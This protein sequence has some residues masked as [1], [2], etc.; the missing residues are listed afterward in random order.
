MKIALLWHDATGT[1]DGFSHSDNFREISET[2]GRNSKIL[3][4]N[5][6]VWFLRRFHRNWFRWYLFRWFVYAFGFIT[7][8][9]PN[10]QTFQNTQGFFPVENSRILWT[11]FAW[12]FISIFHKIRCKDSATKITMRFSS[13]SHFLRFKAFSILLNIAATSLKFFHLFSFES[14]HSSSARDSKICVGT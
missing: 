8:F 12:I 4:T 10:F 6:Q 2:N 9:P 7:E 3:T 5:H 11:K 14:V 1:Y 13:S